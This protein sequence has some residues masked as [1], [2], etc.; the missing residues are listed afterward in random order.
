MLKE[1][2]KEKALKLIDL[3]LSYLELHFPNWKNNRYYLSNYKNFEMPDRLYCFGAN[4]YIKNHKL[5]V[6]SISEEK[7]LKRYRI[8]K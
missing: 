3:L 7:I 4:L 1:K 6:E 5:N 2:N 8:I